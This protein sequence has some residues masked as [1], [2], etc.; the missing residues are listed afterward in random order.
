MKN[1]LRTLLNSRPRVGDSV[2]TKVGFGLKIRGTVK[3]VH[4]GF[5]WIEV[6]KEFLTFSHPTVTAS[7]SYCQFVYL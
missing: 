7:F 4:D 3:S 5:C 2:E 1:L 6:E